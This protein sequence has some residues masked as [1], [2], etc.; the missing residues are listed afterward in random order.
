MVQKPSFVLFILPWFQTIVNQRK[1]KWNQI[2]GIS[3]DDVRGQK[4][5]VLQ[6][7]NK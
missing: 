5:D 4:S 1:K 3:G 6:E 2:H 7:N